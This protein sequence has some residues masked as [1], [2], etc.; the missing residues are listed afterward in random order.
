MDVDLDYEI[1]G[2]VIGRIL[3]LTKKALFLELKWLRVCVSGRRHGGMVCSSTAGAL[4]EMQQSPCM[5]Q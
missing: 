4:T 2:F 5:A 1:L 3:I